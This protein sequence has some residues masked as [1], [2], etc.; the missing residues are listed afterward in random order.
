MRRCFLVTLLLP[1]LILNNGC[2]AHLWSSRELDGWNQ[3]L[4][5]PNL[6]LYD[7]KQEKDFLVVYDE[8]SEYHNAIK[9]RA[10]FLNQNEERIQERHAPQFVSTKLAA[11][12]PAVPVFLSPDILATNQILY[13]VADSNNPPSFTFYWGNK[14]FDSH[15]LPVYKDGMNTA[16]RVAL[17]PLTLAFDVTVVGGIIYIL[18]WTDEHDQTDCDPVNHPPPPY[19]TPGR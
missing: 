10:Y 15:Q 14:E 12:L 6:R 4:T 18:C 5:G 2:T 13:A 7:V 1:L 3:P 8:Y 16:E 9:T 19:S 17:T 11:G